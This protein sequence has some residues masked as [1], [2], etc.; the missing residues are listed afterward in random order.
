MVGPDPAVSVSL[1][2]PPMISVGARASEQDV[3]AGAGDERIV[4]GAV[5]EIEGVVAG[6]ADG[7]HGRGEAGGGGE[8]VAAAAAVED[9][10]RH[11]VERLR[12]LT[13]PRDHERVVGLRRWI[14]LLS[15]GDV[16]GGGGAVN[17][18]TPP[19]CV[20]FGHGVAPGPLPGGLGQVG[21]RS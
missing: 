20:T 5:A 3:L 19:C 8:C 6:P 13:R 10:A 18:T 21:V 15:Q 1:P 2:F 17:V 7:P 12:T 16:V 11:A 4:G 14:H 9:E